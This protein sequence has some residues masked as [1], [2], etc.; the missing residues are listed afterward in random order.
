MSCHLRASA[1]IWALLAHLR[2]H[3][4]S[5]AFADFTR[6]DLLCVGRGV[7]HVVTAVITA[8]GENI[9]TSTPDTETAPAP[10]AEEPKATKKVRV[11]PQRAHIAKKKGKSGKKATPAKKAPKGAKKAKSARE[12]SKTNQVL[13][14][15][16][17]PGGVTARELMK[18]TT[19]QAHSVRGFLSGTIGKKM[20]LAVTSTKGEGGERIYSI[21][22]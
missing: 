15:L 1:G 13:D 11:A 7:I 18:V 9:M 8:Q 4:R 6:I 5:L 20:G 10:V 3:R 2:D 17:Q 16:R 14:L 12:G 21:K 22:S 19:W